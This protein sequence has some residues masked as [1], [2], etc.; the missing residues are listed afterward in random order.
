M[1]ALPETPAE[2]SALEKYLETLKELKRRKDEN[3]LK[4]YLP[5]E[6]Q[7]EFHF[8]GSVFTE[9]LFSA[10]NQLG[11]TWAGAYE[12]AMHLTGQYP[13]WWTGRKWTK[14]IRAMAG[15][16]SAELTVR[17]VQRL[18]VGS[19]EDEDQW[20][21]G[22]IPKDCIV[23]VSRKSGV[24]NAIDSISVKHISGGVSVLKFNSYDQGR[25]KWQ[26]DTVDV[27]WFDEEPPI[28]L[29]MEGITRTNATHGM[30]Y[31][32]FTPL[33]GMSETVDRFYPVPKYV[34]CHVTTMTIY[35][36]EHY[37]LEQKEAI[38]AK[39][40]AHERDA[41]TKGIPMLGSGRIFPLPD[42]A[43][44]IE[45]FPL[46]DL[47]PRISGIDFGWDHPS[48][49]AW[50]AWDRDTDTVYVYDSERVRE[51]TPVQQAP[52]IKRRGDWIPIAWPH[53]GLQHDKGSGQQLAEQYR[54]AGVNML[55]ERA[56]YPETE[57]GRET[58]SRSSVEAGL[59]DML[60][61]M[62]TGK[63]KVFSNQLDWFAEFRMYHRKDGKVVKERDDLM[64]AT[65]YAIMMLRFAI[66]PPDP[67][68]DLYLKR[69]YDW[70]V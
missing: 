52:A 42:E 70:R 35:D 9:R 1:I 18:L 21:T 64:A 34:N 8:A 14:N 20:G 50:L 69:D 48:A 32:T 49:N 6:K 43:V 54:D 3:K 29:Y 17:G 57:D 15:S 19:P 16:E 5:Y 33:K 13:E 39:Y 30:V 51:Q 44:S 28:D 23:K 45:P 2:P 53:D 24:P 56:Q 40:P 68:K 67:T 47:W 55:Y 11:K 41:R 36:V 25:T 7:K 37:T 38:I 27:V 26:A 60:T 31:L 4:Y 46:P 61:R 22:A 65:R 59:L 12:M 58:V 10:G 66:V 63:L 62:Q